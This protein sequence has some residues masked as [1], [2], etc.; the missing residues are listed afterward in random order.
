MEH[1]RFEFWIFVGFE[2]WLCDLGLRKKGNFG[3]NEF[4]F[5]HTIYGI[6][7]IDVGIL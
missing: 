7:K 1:C 3:E 6:V 2:S 4:I 5:R